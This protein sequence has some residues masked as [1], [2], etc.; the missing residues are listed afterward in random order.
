MAF[1]LASTP[2]QETVRFVSAYLDNAT[3]CSRALELQAL[4]PQAHERQTSLT[5]FHARSVPTIDLE[6]YIS[7]ILKYCPCQNEVFLALIVYMQQL[8]DRC[9]RRR[10][11]F[12]VDAYSIHRL[13][14]TAVT[15]GS[16]WF[17]DVFFTNSRYAKVGGLSVA[18]LNNLELQFLSII[19]FDLNVR[20]E[21]LQ[22][23]GTDLF[24]NRLPTLNARFDSMHD[25][26]L[27]MSVHAHPPA[28]ARY[29]GQYPPTYYPPAQPTR[30][31]EP[32]YVYEQSVSRQQKALRHMSYPGPN[33]AYYSYGA[34][35]Y[36][37]TGYKHVYNEGAY[38]DP[39]S[40]S[41]LASSPP[42]DSMPVSALHQNAV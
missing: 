32:Q 26:A 31:Y 22:A 19:D 1:N 24:A 29:P 10:A 36:P 3:Q 11:P 40:G 35:K 27:Y 34:Y 7:R 39:A 41:T 20:P 2:V 38:V 18:E 9:G 33:G 28:S 4:D 30:A 15:I 42:P 5:L 37:E 17:S 16:K 12:T 25:P 14:I 21:T 6:T 23:M 13:V 8:I